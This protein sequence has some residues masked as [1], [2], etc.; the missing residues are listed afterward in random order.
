[1]GKTPSFAPTTYAAPTL[2][3]FQTFVAITLTSIYAPPHST[4]DGKDAEEQELSQ[5]KT[6]ATT[7][8]GRYMVRLSMRSDVAGRVV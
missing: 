1:L 3:A 5:G 8:S 6:S 7:M 4:A 2:P